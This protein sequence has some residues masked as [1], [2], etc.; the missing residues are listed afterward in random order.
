MA[1][2][3]A[4]LHGWPHPP[5]RGHERPLMRAPTTLPRQTLLCFFRIRNYRRVSHTAHL[6]S[7]SCTRSCYA[8]SHTTTTRSPTR[9]TLSQM[10]LTS[11]SKHASSTPPQHNPSSDRHTALHPAIGQGC[12]VTLRAW[13]APR[14]SLEWLPWACLRCADQPLAD[15]HY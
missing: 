2:S 9:T 14:N 13:C 15:Q 4:A 10:G 11:T 12:V 5:R 1:A 7:L 8:C 6:S 3:G